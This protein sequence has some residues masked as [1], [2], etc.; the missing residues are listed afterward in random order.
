ML[1][2]GRRYMQKVESGFCISMAVLDSETTG[3]KEAQGPSGKTQ[4]LH[5]TEK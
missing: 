3:T 1:E 5:C 4:F 2:G